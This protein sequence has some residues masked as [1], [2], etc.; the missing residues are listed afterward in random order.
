MS[1]SLAVDSGGTKV[2]AILYDEKFRQL[3]SCRVGSMRLNTTP[4]AVAKKHADE[5][6]CALGLDGKELD[7]VCGI[8]EDTLKTELEKRCAVTQFHRDS[9]AMLGFYASCVFRDGCLVVAGTGATVFV[10]KDGREVSAGGYGNLVADEGSG[11]WI[12]KEAMMAAVR[13][14]ENRGER[15][16]L[17]D[18]IAKMMGG[19]RESF[20]ER[21]FAYVYGRENA[22]PAACVSGCCRLVSKASQM[23]DE[24]ALQIL[25]RAGQL[26]AQQAVSL[27]GK[28][29]MPADTP[30]ALCGSV[31]RSHHALRDA[32]D[33]E[34][35]RLC[36][37]G[38]VSSPVFEPIVG[39]VI[40]HH[41][42]VHGGFSAWDKGILM[43]NFKEYLFDQR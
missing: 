20:R 23:G 33:G 37:R 10:R 31:W 32:F 35:A 18:L 15:T 40:G 25:S 7:T 14:Y 22:S 11:Y 24:M 17:T 38:H 5:L 13:D 29:Q 30:I 43:E 42:R 8:F 34:L 4:L 36:H 19:S 26:L 12:G 16:C 27:M 39:A 9:E 6:I 41:Q 3:S 21:L 28:E 1:Y 2:Q